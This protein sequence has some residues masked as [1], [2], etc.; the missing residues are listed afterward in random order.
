MTLSGEGDWCVVLWQWDQFKML[1]KFDLG[2][3]DPP[4]PLTFQ[5]SL[6][7]IRTNMICLVTGVD[8]YKYLTLEENLRSFN[9]VH[10]ELDTSGQ[11][12]STEYTCHTWTKG[13]VQLVLATA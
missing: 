7:Q 3:V 13:T 12:V 8:T 5:V 4:E 2:L 9:E 11:E 10:A 6:Y 1:A